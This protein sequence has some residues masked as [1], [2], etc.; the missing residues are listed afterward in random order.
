MMLPNVKLGI[1]DIPVI[2]L[3]RDITHIV[4]GE[5]FYFEAGTPLYI[6][7]DELTMSTMIETTG[8][9]GMALLI[10]KDKILSMQ[11]RIAQGGQVGELHGPL[12]AIDMIGDTEEW[13]V[14]E[15]MNSL[16]VKYDNS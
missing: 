14:R 13:L 11:E 9:N 2:I 16:R 1:C 3:R 12:T 4:N 8:Y 15:S 6:K 5:K 10:A 7:K